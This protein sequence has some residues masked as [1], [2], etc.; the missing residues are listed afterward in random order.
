MIV[1]RPCEPTAR[2]QAGTP[3]A[4]PV[5]TKHGIYSADFETPRIQDH[6]CDNTIELLGWYWCAILRIFIHQANMVDNKQGN[7][8]IIAQTKQTL[9]AHFKFSYALGP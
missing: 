9:A 2:P 7:Q 4:Q 8:T 6:V 1:C 5:Q 3:G